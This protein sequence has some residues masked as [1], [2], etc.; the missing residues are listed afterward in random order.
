MT[1]REIRRVLMTMEPTE[2][3]A[4]YLK[5]A[6]G[7]HSEPFRLLRPQKN[8]PG[9]P[10]IIKHA[11]KLPEE[12]ISATKLNLDRVR[13]LARRVAN[14]QQVLTQKTKVAP[15]RRAL[16]RLRDSCIEFELHVWRLARH[17]YEA[18]DGGRSGLLTWKT[19]QQNLLKN[20]RST[21][22]RL[23]PAHPDYRAVSEAYAR[24]K[25]MAAQ[26]KGTPQIGL[27][28][29]WQRLRLG[30]K[31]WRVAQIRRRLA[32]E[33]FHSNASGRADVFDISLEVALKRFQTVHSL[34][35]DGR[36]VQA[37][38]RELRPSLRDR[39]AQLSAVLAH[40]RNRPHRGAPYRIQVNIP[41]FYLVL[42]RKGRALRRHRVVVGRVG[43]SRDGKLRRNGRINQT[44]VLA[45]RINAL[46]L[47]PAWRVPQRIKETELDVIAQ[48]NPTIYDGFRLYTDARG[49][50][51][52]VQLPGRG[53]ALGIV[54][55]AFPNRHSVF[56]HD[57][58][59]KSLF[60]QTN[61]T[62]SHGCVRV[63]DAWTLAALILDADPG[64]LTSNRARM[65]MRAPHET[66]I[67]LSKPV[68]VFLE[69]VTAGTDG[70][71]HFRFFPDMYELGPVRAAQS[72]AP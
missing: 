31:D 45:G 16:K 22:A 4:S 50:E 51:R 32:M 1:Q 52:A 63:E 47:N 20:P 26:H 69:Y 53:N 57:T 8:H 49:I 72:A 14:L 42:Y 40:L 66:P 9:V 7:A 37:T 67:R 24:Y 25:R 68:P 71:G 48:T 18:L 12:G 46:V 59:R 29:T 23:G 64:T 28:K 5:W 10:L 38:L 3:T 56:L 35:V 43:R 33:G 61:R 21:L 36:P 15:A 54:K 19:F 6:L 44:P 60:G 2:V 30:T 27:G 55:F 11:A 70:L 62:F 58:P 41:G 17:V 39:T 13:F 34:E 65:L